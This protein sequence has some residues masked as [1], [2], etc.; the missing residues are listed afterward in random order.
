M[1]LISGAINDA[2]IAVG[3]GLMSVGETALEA[4]YGVWSGAAGIT[5]SYAR[6]SP[7]SQGNA[8]ALVTGTQSISGITLC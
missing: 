1:G 7:A 4:A 3:S 5:I 6:Q 2:L 8:W